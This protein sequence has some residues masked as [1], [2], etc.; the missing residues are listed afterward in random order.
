MANSVLIV[1]GKE[2]RDDFRN[3]WV[4]AITGLFASLALAI[5]YFGAVTTGHIGF[6]SFDATIASM[7]TLAAF[8]VPLI[9]L[10][11]AHDTIINE[12]DN[13]TLPLLLSYP[14]SRVELAAGKFLGH[15]V[16]LMIATAAGFAAAVAAIQILSPQARD[17]NAWFSI[18]QFVLSASLL[19]M[20]FVGLACLISVKAKTKAR[21]AGLALLAWFALVVLFDLTL[22]AILVV[23]GGNATEQAFYPYL[24]LLNPIDV[25]RLINLVALKGSGGSTFFMAM[26]ADHAYSMTALYG[27]LMVW[28]VGPFAITAL[29]F[30]KQEI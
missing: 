21:A 12:Q 1:A 8:V 29:A 20:S 17:L 22:L 10:L 14:L 23:S 28:A 27:A 5:A 18:T 13:G 4:I 30:R 26:S 11:V 7:T 2:L 25:F 3:H 24:L 6:T 15:S 9:A 19:G 16:M